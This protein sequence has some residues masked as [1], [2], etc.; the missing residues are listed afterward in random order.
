MSPAL[1]LEFMRAHAPLRVGDPE[2]LRHRH[3]PRALCGSE[4]NTPVWLPGAW[5]QGAAAKRT[6]SRPPSNGVQQQSEDTG[7][8]GLKSLFGR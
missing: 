8:P 7:K 2:S 3:C 6:V 5:W 4:P 1:S